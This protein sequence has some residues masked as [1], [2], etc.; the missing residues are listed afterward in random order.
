MRRFAPI[1][2]FALCV[3]LLSFPGF[4][5]SKNVLDEKL[6]MKTLVTLTKHGLLISLEDV[7]GK[8]KYR[9]VSALV[10]AAPDKV[11]RVL[12]RFEDYGNFVPEMVQ[13]VI[14]KRT[15]TET[16]VAFTL[17]IRILGPI[18]STQNYKTRY[19]FKKPRL[20]MYSLDDPRLEPGYWEVTPVDGGKKT[21]LFYID[22]AP[23]LMKMGTLVSS[24]VKAKP[25]LGLAIQVSPITIL[26][27]AIKT[28]SEKQ[29]SQIK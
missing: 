16:V 11:W 9:M 12:T 18:K 23:D 3:F 17:E 27:Q 20:Y 5:R 13:P 19:V 14:E 21:L 28:E 2:A 15:K 24:V 22:T 29:G 1:V 6:D 25:E 8:L 7:D 10:N 26:V 4:A